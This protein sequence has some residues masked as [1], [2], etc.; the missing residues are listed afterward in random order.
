MENITFSSI[1][2]PLLPATIFQWLLATF[3]LSVL[4]IILTIT[5]RLFLH[6]LASIPGPR[7]AATTN[8]YQVFLYFRGGRWEEGDYQMRLHE[9][10]GLLL[11]SCPQRRLTEFCM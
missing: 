1:L 10:Y 3:L 9:K 4:T 8:L 7:L 5:Y 2:A 11:P 6:P